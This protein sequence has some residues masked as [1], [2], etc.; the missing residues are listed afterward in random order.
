MIKDIAVHL[1]G[2]KEDDIRLA[3]AESL[4]GRFDAHLTGLLMHIDPELLAVP[5]P[6]VAV[7]LD[8]WVAEAQ[9]ATSKRRAQLRQRF[10][11]MAAQNDLRVVS[12]FRAAIGEELAREARTSDLFVGTRP[13]G[14]PDKSQRIEEAV[15]FGS[16]RACLWLPPQNSKVWNFSSVLVAWKDSRESARALKDAIPFLKAADQVTLALVND[17]PGE[18]THSTEGTDV[19]RYLSRHGVSAIIRDLPGWHSASAAILNET[20]QIGA[21]LIVAGGYGHSRLQQWLLGGV[22]RTLLSEC[23]VPVLMAR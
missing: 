14:D 9:S 6:T 8:T 17:E 19:A 7:L 4:A 21:D 20:S 3:V 16:G 11:K 15:L 22:T 13:Y 23:P 12:G 10:S 2:S 1:T 5:D 18:E